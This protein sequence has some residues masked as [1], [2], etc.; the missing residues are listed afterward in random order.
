MTGRA[1]ADCI[2][3]LVLAVL[4]AGCQPYTTVYHTR[5]GYYKLASEDPLPDE[6]VDDDG[7]RHVYIER[8]T[9]PDGRS[10]T[11]RNAESFKIRQ[12]DDDGHVT[13]RAVLPA[14]VVMNTLTCFRNEEYEVLWDQLVSTQ[15]KLAWS[16]RGGHEADFVAWC[17]QYRLDVARMLTRMSLGLSSGET[18]VEPRD[19]FVVCRFWPHVAQEFRFK[20]VWMTREGFGLMLV[21]IR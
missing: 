21:A 20:E 12:E 15:T 8:G 18:V 3:M 13:L 7:V 1:R 2:P 10:S 5:P 6:F 9:T 16:E 19:G 17:R 4:S 14:H 11:Q